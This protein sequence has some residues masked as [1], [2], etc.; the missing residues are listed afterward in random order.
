VILVGP[1][2][3]RVAQRLGVDWARNLDDALAMARE[4]SGEDDVV[5]L[6]MPPFFY[7]NV[8]GTQ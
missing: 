3:P 8:G 6:T 5:A 4:I 2:E 1:K 7:A